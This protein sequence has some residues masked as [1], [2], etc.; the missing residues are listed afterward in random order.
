[1]KSNPIV[2]TCPSKFSNAG[3]VPGSDGGKHF[4]HYPARNKIDQQSIFG[5][6]ISSRFRF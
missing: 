4:D 1:M 6:E 2:K 3:N 5:H